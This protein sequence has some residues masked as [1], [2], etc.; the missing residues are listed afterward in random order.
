MNKSFEKLEINHSIKDKSF[1]IHNFKPTV[2]DLRK[3]AD[4]KIRNENKLKFISN[5]LENI[6]LNKGITQ[7]IKI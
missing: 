5:G 2:N 3:N 4:I 7:N 6:S 1:K